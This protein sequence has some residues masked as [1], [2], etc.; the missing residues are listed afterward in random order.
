MFSKPNYTQTPNDFFDKVLPTLKD[1]EMRVL[2]IVMRQTFG[3]GNKEWDRIS[4]SQLV[5]KTGLS[6]QT[7]ITA[8]NSLVQKKLLLKRKE[9][10]A[11][12][13]QSWYS[14][15]VQEP[16]EFATPI[17]NSNNSYPS[18][19][20]TPPS[21]NFRP[22]KE[23]LTKERRKESSLKGAKEKSATPPPPS[24]FFKEKFEGKIQVSEEN[25]KRLVEKFKDPAIINW[26]AEKLYRYSIQKPQKFRQY[27][28]HDMVI[29]DWIERDAQKAEAS[30]S[31]TPALNDAQMKN[32]M[33]NQEVVQDL[34]AECPNRASGLNFYYKAHLLKDKNN[35]SF[36]ISG[37]IDH[38]TFCMQ[39]Q[40]HL[41]VD[42]MKER[43]PN[44]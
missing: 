23:T 17:D 9:G 10:A 15:M 40:K 14:L 26:Y 32:W 2:L 19:F 35:P 13:E 21:L 16:T 39:L 11:G 41:K 29:E 44:G 24:G 5:E 1:G 4:I 12:K 36:D 38:K 20:E 3:W 22:T 25:M 8:T 27:K 33:L 7:V 6:R 30:K 18:K 28:R 43:F 42:I 34:K 31:S 37:L